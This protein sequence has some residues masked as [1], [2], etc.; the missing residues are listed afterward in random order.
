MEQL[1]PAMPAGPLGTF[2]IL[3]L[4]SLLVPPLA[5]QL[6]LPGLVGLIG[7]GAVLGEHGLNW[8]DADSE[9]MQLL[10]DIGKIYLMFVAGLEI[11]LAEFRRARNRSLS[12]GVA[13][14]VLPLL[15]GLLVGRAFGSDWNA[16]ILLGSLMSSQTLLAY[17]IVSRLGVAR[18]EPVVVTIGATIFTDIAALLLLA[19]SIS[20]HTG[21]FSP[22][23]LIAQVVGLALYAAVVLVGF[24]WAGRRYIQRTGDEQSNQF[25]F[26]L[27]A[28]FLASVG[29]QAINIDRIVGAFLAGLAVNDAIG[30]S[31]VE[32]KV[33][34]V[35]S[36]LFIP[37]FFINIGL[38]VDFPVFV[39]TLATELG[40][41]A[42]VVV[43]LVGSKFLGALAVARCFRYSWND[44][45]VMGSLSLPQVAATL[46]AALAGLETGVLS[47][48]LFNAVIVLMLVT[49]LLGPLLT[50][51][52]ASKMPPPKASVPPDGEPL[53][54]AISTEGER[55]ADRP[56]T[57]VVPLS[58]AG[59]KA[60]LL[61]TAAL[62]AQHESG[63]LVPLAIVPSRA[64]MDDPQLETAIAEAERH[65]GAAGTV[66]SQLSV[67]TQRY[68]RIDSNPADGIS[69]AAR[70]YDADLIVMG[71]QDTSRLQAR[72]FG[73]T[74]ERVLWSAHCPVAV[75]HLIAPP[76]Q[77]ERI[78]VPVK[79]LTP[80]A[81][82]AIRFAQLFAD[83]HS[84]AI[85]LLHVGDRHAT[86]ERLAAFE[87]ELSQ[88]AERG[89]VAVPTR[90]LTVA[91]DDAA[92]A[93]A[94]RSQAFDLV[95]LRSLRRRTAGGLA[96]SEVTTRT[97]PELQCSFILF[98]EAHR[99]H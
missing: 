2:T 46:A 77:L 62:L 81:V 96:V 87:R 6:R 11:D 24:D 58:D 10:S 18:S 35:G 54:E 63:Q 3:L 55:A 60:D 33:Q 50:E 22:F 78:L 90:V 65:L 5:Q 70:Q 7:A 31:P 97:I 74:T 47:E 29:A 69:R 53:G 75:A 51:R 99:A 41:A 37:F 95:V 85:T 9:T 15:A 43:V 26:V 73:T 59:Q 56:F 34:F 30:H 91:H 40:L 8:I 21:G 79:T 98:G 76:S 38:L 23:N 12:F 88:V 42:A 36:S 68:L 93:I 67:P 80:Q 27:L 14:F 1:L 92:A 84:A 32:E 45:A 89:K 94:E 4:V 16:S 66:E 17:P 86:T 82:Q 13:T 28:V 61:A 64:R 39:E 44:M 49:A 48:E 19:V 71:W 20:I 57:V 72:L 52:F 83:A 25:L